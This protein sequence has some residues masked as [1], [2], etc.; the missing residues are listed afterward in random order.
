MIIQDRYRLFLY[1]LDESNKKL[2]R[3]LN[4][5]DWS[6]GFDVSSVCSRHLPV[7]LQ[8]LEKKRLPVEKSFMLNFHYLPKEEALRFDTT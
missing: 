8:I 5:L 3:I 6:K 7:V 1:T 2:K 4:L